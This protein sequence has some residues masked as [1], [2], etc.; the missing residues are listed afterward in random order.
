MSLL[1]CKILLSF[2]SRKIALIY[3]TDNLRVFFDDISYDTVLKHENVSNLD[4][5]FITSKAT[6]S[7]F[8]EY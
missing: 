2:L 1:K 4:A 7:M 3:Q 8:I 6:L 5:F